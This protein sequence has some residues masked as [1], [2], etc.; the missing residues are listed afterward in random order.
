MQKTCIVGG[1]FGVVTFAWDLTRWTREKWKTTW[2]L[3][4]WYWLV[5]RNPQ[6]WHKPY[7][8]KCS[9]I[10]PLYNPNHSFTR[11]FL[12]KVS[13]NDG[14]MIFVHLHGTDDTGDIGPSTE[15]KTFLHGRGSCRTF[16]GV[17]G[18][19]TVVVAWV[20]QEIYIYTGYTLEGFYI[21]IYREREICV[22]FVV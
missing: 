22:I 19:K 2:N 8:Q 7:K 3:L 12:L 9:I 6:L 4:T 10:N 20:I 11:F 18:K 14:D 17:R 13:V 15:M 5:N 21:Y 1:H 16:S